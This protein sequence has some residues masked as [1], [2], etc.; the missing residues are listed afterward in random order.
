M[1]P[2][3]L[4]ILLVED[5][6]GDV[7]LTKE[8]LREAKLL[9]EVH[10]VD[11]G[12]RALAFLR[13]QPPYEESCTPDLVLLDLNLPRMDGKQVLAEMKSDPALRRIPVVV[14]TTSQDERDVLATYN[15]HANCYI[16]KPVDLDQFLDVVRS[17]EH[18]WLALVM[19]PPEYQRG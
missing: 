1:G 18:F 7:R 6:P 17:I 3:M 12:E 11:D 9:N 5:N 4:D 13:H 15:L 19:L 10:A 8:A 2:K 16:A 14:L